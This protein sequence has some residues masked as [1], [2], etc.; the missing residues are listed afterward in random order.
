MRCR[1]WWRCFWW[2]CVGAAPILTV[3]GFEEHKLALARGDLERLKAAGRPIAAVDLRIVDAED[4]EVP[5]GEAGEVCVRGP[6]VTAGYLNQPE[7]TATAM[8]NGWFHTGDV[9]RV[10]AAGYL[11]LLDRKKD[12]V[13][14]GGEN[15]YSSEVEQAIYQHP[16]V[17]ECAVV[18]VPDE[19]Y[20]EALLAAVVPAPGRQIT[21]EAL[22]AHCRAR[23]GGYK[24]PRRMVFLEQLPKSAMGK[25]LKTELR[26]IYAASAAGAAPRPDHPRSEQ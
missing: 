6:N 10:D 25:I 9:G 12:I 21:Q 24:I 3:L 14:T 17:S 20:G 11:Y 15:V 13:I 1:R 26:R 22:I 8:R 2:A 18:G 16:D 23:I 5:T 19:T 7:V 4:R